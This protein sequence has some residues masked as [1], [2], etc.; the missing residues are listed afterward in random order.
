MALQKTYGEF[1]QR[2]EVYASCLV[3][4]PEDAR[5]IVSAAFASVLQSPVEAGDGFLI[6]YLYRTVHNLCLNHRR[7][8]ARHEAARMRIQEREGRAFRYYSSLLESCDPSALFVSEISEIYNGLLSHMSAEIQQ[9][10]LLRREGHSYKEIAR[11]LGISENRV[12]KNLRKVLAGL[13]LSLSD[14]L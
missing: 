8:S 1:R 10:Y 14:Y 12:D 6:P 7:D 13:K 9:T 5:D 11:R 4:D 2:L 3:R